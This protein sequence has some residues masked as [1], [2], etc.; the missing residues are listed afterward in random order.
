MATLSTIRTSVRTKYLIETTASFWTDAELLEFIVSGAR[1][2][3]RAVIGLNAEHF[4]VIDATNVSLA[5]NTAT[6]TGVPANVHRVRFIQPRDLTSANNSRGVSFHP[7]D[8]NSTEFRAALS[9]SAVDPSGGYKIYYHISGQGSPIAAPTIYV[10]PQLSSALNLTLGYIKT[11]TT[12]DLEAGD[13]NPIPGESDQALEFWCAAWANGK[14]DESG[15][16]RPEPVLLQAYATE[17][18]SILAALDPRQEHE[19]KVVQGPFDLE[20]ENFW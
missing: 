18:A 3:W 2:L 12:T 10:A 19:P 6:L 17:K 5:A 8:Y 14:Q 15:V 13:E 16:W 1:D 4:E 9:L 11:I 20:Q 7:R